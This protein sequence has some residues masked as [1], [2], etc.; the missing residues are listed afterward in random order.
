[1][2]KTNADKFNISNFLMTIAPGTAILL[3]PL[4]IQLCSP[5]LVDN[6][7]HCSVLEQQINHDV[8]NCRT[9]YISVN[10]DDSSPRFYF[11]NSHGDIVDEGHSVTEPGYGFMVT[12]GGNIYTI[13][14]NKWK[15]LD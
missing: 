10:C 4:G 6:K 14:D 5:L 3:F 15:K 9:G 1:M 8:G 11:R 13:I 2:A 12:D 7:Q